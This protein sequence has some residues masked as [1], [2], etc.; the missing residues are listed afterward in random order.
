MVSVYAS[1]D[2]ARP[3]QMPVLTQPPSWEDLAS[4]QRTGVQDQKEG[5]PLD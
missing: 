1:Q 2:T 3:R 5:Q 4:L